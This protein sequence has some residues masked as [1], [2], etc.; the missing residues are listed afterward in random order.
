MNLLRIILP[1]IVLFALEYYAFQSFSGWAKT[2]TTPWKQIS[3]TIYAVFT[4]GV[5]AFLFAF[6]V[7]RNSTAYPG[8]KTISTVLLMAI[9]VA[10]MGMAIV[11]SLDDLR[12]LFAYAI[13]FFTGKNADAVATTNAISRSAFMQKASILVGGTLF[14]TLVYGARNRYNYKVHTVAVPVPNVPE[15]LKKLRIVQISD[16]HSGSFTNSAAVE[17]GIQTI[18]NLNPDL[19]FFTGDLVNNKANEML[20]YIDIFGKLKATY[21]VY[22]SLGNHDYGDYVQWS[23][24]R[25]K[26]QNLNDLKAIHQQMGWNLLL[27]ENTIIDINGTPLAIIGV[28]NISGSNKFHSYGDFTKACQGVESIAH[29]ILLSHDPS[30]WDAEVKNSN[31][32]IM[33]TLSG[34]TH[35][36]QFGIDIP[37]F[38]KWSPVQYIYK[39]WAGLYTENNQHLYVNR[40]FG[41]LGYSGRVGILPEVTAIKFV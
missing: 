18:L 38:I 33:L 25:E 7:L 32:N 4:I 6:P 37:G 40:G 31:A 29:K 5:F 36:M 2:L 16:V 26:V 23:S 35:G 30:H 1:L 11:L 19:I 13:Q 34:H 14:G 41:F 39:K 21:G 20:P 24:A 22:S 9:V 27:N 3:I 12:R 8:L 10:K 17:K 28:E 15:A